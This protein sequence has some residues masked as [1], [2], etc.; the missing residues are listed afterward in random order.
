MNISTGFT[1]TAKY[2]GFAIPLTKVEMRKAIIKTIRENRMMYGVVRPQVS[3]GEG[4]ATADQLDQIRNPN[5]VIMPLRTYP[6]TWLDEKV[7]PLRA[8]IVSTRKPPPQSTEVRAK[9]C[10]YLVN[11]LGSLQRIASGAD[12]ADNA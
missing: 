9:H 4:L 5:V 3:R 1:D 12:V 8:I 6:A 2:L 10:N 7:E 11:V